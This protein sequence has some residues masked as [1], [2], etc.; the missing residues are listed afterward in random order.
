MIDLSELTAPHPEDPA[1]PNPAPE[2][3]P[4]HKIWADA[5]VE[6]LAEIFR[7]NARMMA[8]TPAPAGL[9]DWFIELAFFKYQI[10]AKR[11][12]SIVRRPEDARAYEL[13]LDNYLQE[14]VNDLGSREGLPAAIVKAKLMEA[15]NYWKGNAWSQV[16]DVA[17]AS[18]QIPK[19]PAGERSMLMDDLCSWTSLKQ[20]FVKCG[21][22]YDG[23]FASYDVLDPGGWTLDGGSPIAQRKFRELAG[24]ARR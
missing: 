20:A 23:L 24:A 16:R 21:A 14:W 22:E 1:G 19:N 12:L 15:C 6:A 2:G 9:P 7:L 5:T 13:W 3:H 11:N 17:A 4:A 10:W 18:E 8:K